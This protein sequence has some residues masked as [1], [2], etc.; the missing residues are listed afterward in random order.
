MFTAEEFLAMIDAIY[1]GILDQAAWEAAVARLCRAFG[2]EA[3]ALSL[4]DARS[5]AVV[6]I[7]QVNVDPAYQR[8]YG[9]LI[10]LPDMA[11][12]FRL[13]RR[14]RRPAR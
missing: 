12:A 2:G 5:F 8:T 10:K 9:E 7:V 11:G 14:L 13:I 6:D 4:H 1:A 3:A